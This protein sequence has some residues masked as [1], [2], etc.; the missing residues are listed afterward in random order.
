MANVCLVEE[1]A[2][3]KGQHSYVVMSRILPHPGLCQPTVFE[4]CELRN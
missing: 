2:A 4:L 1:P 3:F